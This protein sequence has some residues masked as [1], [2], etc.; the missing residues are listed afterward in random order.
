VKA[1]AQPTAPQPA[2]YPVQR[3]LTAAMK[4]AGAR[5]GDFHRMQVW[6]GQSAAMA[7][8]EPASRVVQRIWADA[9]ALL[10]AR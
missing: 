6:A 9:R 1:M 5:T 4:Q 2:R 8:A 7:N 10:Q 3:A